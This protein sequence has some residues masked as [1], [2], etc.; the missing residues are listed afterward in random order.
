LKLLCETDFVAK[1]ENFLALAHSIATE[2]SVSDDVEHYDAVDTAIQEKIQK[3]LTDNA[4]KIGENMQ[5]AQVL[6]TSKP[7]YGYTHPGDKVA[8]VVFYEGDA[9][10]AKGVALQ[11]AAMNPTYFNLDAVPQSLK[12]SLTEEAKA[13]FAD[14]NKPADIVEKIVSGKVMKQLSEDVLMEQ[15][16]IIDSN[17]KV[18]DMM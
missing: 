10:K 18:K 7:A 2:L 17:Q 9:D 16:S 6:V 4:L 3:H 5:I 15:E 11:V 12:D 13:E 14:S 1:N 8:A